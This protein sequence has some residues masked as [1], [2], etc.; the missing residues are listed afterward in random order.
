M[1]PFLLAASVLSAALHAGEFLALM[2]KAD[3]RGEPQ[4]KIEYYGRALRA[5]T[6]QD[7]QALLANC[8]FRRGEAFFDS[9]KLQQSLPDLDKAL[10]LDPRN[11]QAYLLRGKI[12]LIAGRFKKAA[13][14]LGEYAALSPEDMD[15]LLS[16]GEAQR[17]SGKKEPSLSTYRKAALLEPADFRPRLGEALT[18]MDMK[19][20]PAAKNALDE[21]DSL[22]RHRDPETLALR[23][24]ARD[25]LGDRQG[26]LQDYTDSLPLHEARLLHL[27]RASAPAQETSR[28]RARTAGAYYE[29]GRLHERL[30]RQAQALPDYE[31]ACRLGHDRACARAAT[32]KPAA[33]TQS[34][35]R[36]AKPSNDLGDRIYAN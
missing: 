27:S 23:G 5:W 29:R 13:A 17:R 28:Q 1:T 21:A 10:D 3:G 22:A 6:P 26:A 14:D 31:Q 30:N 16:L 18:Y 11:A 9:G 25:A 2:R 36:P 33:K 7:G 32:L 34:K 24:A 35:P 4:E 19:R 15:G 8:H 12:H 20:W